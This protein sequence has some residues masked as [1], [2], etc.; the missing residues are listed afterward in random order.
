MIAKSCE[1]HFVMNCQ[2]CRRNAP[3]PEVEPVVFGSGGASGPSPVVVAAPPITATPAAITPAISAFIAP[4][5][6]PIVLL[7]SE[8]AVARVAVGDAERSVKVLQRSLED[9]MKTLATAKI[10]AAE[11]HTQLIKA[12][13]DGL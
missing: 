3:V 8:D 2:I 1:A 5:A 11:T 9:A 6:D 13:T 4:A 12:V 10:R 7:A